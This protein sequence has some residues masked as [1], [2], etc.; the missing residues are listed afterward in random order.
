MNHEAREGQT[1]LPL[2]WIFRVGLETGWNLIAWPWCMA[3]LSPFAISSS[4]YMYLQSVQKHT[5][6][7]SRRPRQAAQENGFI[8]FIDRT[9]RVLDRC[10]QSPS[11]A[12]RWRVDAEP[13]LA[14]QYQP[15]RC[16]GTE[17]VWNSSCLAETLFFLVSNLE[18]DFCT[19]LLVDC[20]AVSEVSM[21]WIVLGRALLWAAESWDKC[22]FFGGANPK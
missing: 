1:L 11:K 7:W 8:G 17:L 14:T 21:Y 12:M 20:H 3:I 5:G 2:P 9:D 6:N 4:N 15:W 16:K 19:L 18:Q 10:S 13:G 22:F